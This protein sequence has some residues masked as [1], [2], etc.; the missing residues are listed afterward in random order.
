MT[1]RL[2]FGS[3]GVP[4]CSDS[5]AHCLNDALFAVRSR[6]HILRYWSL[7]CVYVQ[8]WALELSSVDDMQKIQ[9]IAVGSKQISMYGGHYGRLKACIRCAHVRCS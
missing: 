4:F 7:Q 3:H 8:I 6:M 9:L 5:Y 2:L 1:Y